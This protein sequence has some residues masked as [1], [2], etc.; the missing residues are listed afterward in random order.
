M[1]KSITTLIED[2]QNVLMKPEI[3]KEQA[4]ILGKRI[5][6][7]IYQKFNRSEERKL[8]MSNMGTPC[9]R[10]LWYSLNTPELGE[11][12]SPEA[13]LKFLYG[14][15][16]EE[17]VLWLAEVAGH[18]VTGRQD[19]AVINGIEG[20][21][22]A[23]IDGHLV[24]VKS[25]STYSFKKFQSH[26]QPS[27][28][29]FGYLSQLGGY[30]YSYEK[31]CGSDR[32]P[33]PP[34]FLVIDKTLGKICLDFQPDVGN[35]DYEQLAERKRAVVNQPAPPGRRYFDEPD[36]LSGNRKLGI[37]CSYCDFKRQCW[38]GLRTFV[39]S[40]GPRFLTSVVRLPAVPEYS[41]HAG[42]DTGS[43]E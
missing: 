17:L 31:E 9:E 19:R 15:I 33:G 39:Y 32:I 37:N 5:A 42:E 22:D 7:T 21:R 23:I 24:D 14:D 29:T 12:L 30:Q 10:K 18:E 8:R 28:D 16:I 41:P 25:A 26:L 1:T 36:G 3:T 34:A 43:E 38:P 20:H 6:E 4:D 13:R 27:D 11:K 40:T 2:I 35:T